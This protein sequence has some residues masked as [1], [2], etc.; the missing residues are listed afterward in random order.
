MKTVF[1]RYFFAP[2]LSFSRQPLK[3]VPAYYR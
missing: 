3:L 2:H 1:E